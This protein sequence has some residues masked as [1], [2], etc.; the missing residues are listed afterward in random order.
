MTRKEQYVKY[1][2]EGMGSREAGRKAGYSSGP[3]TAAIHLYEL[4]LEMK[5]H[6]HVCMILPQREDD[7]RQR[8]RDV[9]LQRKACKLAGV[10]F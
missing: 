5:D 3:S 10:E 6:P 4:A 9:R 8:L 2:L 1:R 7:L